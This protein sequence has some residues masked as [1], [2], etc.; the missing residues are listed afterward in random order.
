MASPVNQHCAKCIGALS[1]PARGTRPPVDNARIVCGA[2]S[3][4]L[5]GIRL[6]VRP[7]IGRPHAAAAGLLL[8]AR[9]PGDV[10]RLL[11]DRRLSRKCE[12]CHVVS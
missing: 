2:V 6:S 9:R 12:Q 10:D 4:K 1:F 8:W 5:S 3:T 11:H 7:I